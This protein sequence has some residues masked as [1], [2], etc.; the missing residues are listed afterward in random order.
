MPTPPR[1]TE[2]Q[3]ELDSCR[4]QFT[5]APSFGTLRKLAELWLRTEHWELAAQAF[6]HVARA[7][8]SDAQAFAGAAEALTHLACYDL[9]ARLWDR[10]CRMQPDNRVYAEAHARA[11]RDSK[12]LP[13]QAK[14]IIDRTGF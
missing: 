3:V 9:A 1:P 7:R 8:P 10:A 2:D 5:A 11:L 13:A 4:H 14:S 6:L 12:S